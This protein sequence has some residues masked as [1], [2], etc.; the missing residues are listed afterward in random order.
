MTSKRLEEQCGAFVSPASVRFQGVKI[1]DV[2]ERNRP[3]K[4][5]VAF[6]PGDLEVDSVSFFS[7]FWGATR[8]CFRTRR[9]VPS[10]A[11]I[12][13]QDHVRGKQVCMFEARRRTRLCEDV[14][15]FPK[16]GKVVVFIS[17]LSEH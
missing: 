17:Y 3:P 16:Q 13:V 6:E 11:P 1:I 12:R 2:I 15:G 5:S 7:T 14:R 4:S 9:G 8:G 10:D